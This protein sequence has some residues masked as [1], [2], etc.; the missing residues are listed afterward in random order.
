MSFMLSRPPHSQDPDADP[1]GMT[2][3]GWLA[4]TGITVFV[5]SISLFIFTLILS[6]ASSGESQNP[7]VVK[8]TRRLS[9]LSPEELATR[10]QGRQMPVTSTDSSV[11]KQFSNFFLD[12][13]YD[14]GQV[15]ESVSGRL[16]EKKGLAGVCAAPFPVN[17]SDRGCKLVGHAVSGSNGEK[18]TAMDCVS[19]QHSGLHSILVRKENAIRDCVVREAET[20]GIVEFM[21]LSSP[22]PVIDYIQLDVKSKELGILTKFPF[23]EYCS[24]SWTIKYIPAQVDALRNILEI[25]QGCEIRQYDVTQELWA[26]CPCDKKRPVTP[27]SSKSEKPEE[28]R[29]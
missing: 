6:Y 3:T 1:K 17:F 26:R 14:S 12:I 4:F 19:P 8:N 2:T 11:T 22:P 13:G 21:R 27:V 10:S 29:S 9:D 18:V 25:G 16:C 23:H 7:M 28:L 20:I 5:V 24:K 15:W